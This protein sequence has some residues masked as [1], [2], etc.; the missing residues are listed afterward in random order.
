[1][2]VSEVSVEELESALQSGA[3]LVDVREPDEY[4][5]GHVPGAILVPLASVP[6]SLDQFDAD[7]TTYVI[8]K[9]GARSYRA[10]EFLVDQGLDAANVEGGT[11]AWI[12]SGRATVAGD[13]PA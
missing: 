3:R 2:S 1:M 12:I 7:A 13:Q 8:C 6:T 4:Q 10:C 11:M 5:A 9:T